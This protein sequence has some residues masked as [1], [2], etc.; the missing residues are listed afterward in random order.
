MI[1]QSLCLVLGAG[2]SQPYG[3]PTGNGLLRAATQ[4]PD[5]WWPLVGEVL[6]GATRASHEAFLKELAA[7]GAES[8]DEF[9]GKRTEYKDYAKAL[10]AYHI[11]QCERPDRVL[12]AER[13]HDW[14][15]FLIRRISDGAT[16]PNLAALDISVVTF[17]FDRS[18]EECLLARLS[19]TYKEPGESPASARTRVVGAIAN[20]KL[21]HVHGSL[22]PLPELAMSGPGRAYE[23]T[24]APQMLRQAMDGII[25]LNDAQSG[26]KEFTAA[27]ELIRSASRVFFLG[28]GFHRLNCA[29]VLPRKEDWPS[30]GAIACGTIQGLTKGRIQKVSSYFPPSINLRNDDSLALLQEYEAVFSD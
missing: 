26:S 14:L 30:P 1:T 7:S 9:V 11:G 23:S 13:E 20:W 4:M 28:F 18:Y 2:A 8:L 10:I 29:R 3:F 6:P 5:E 21:I 27:R 17:N 22:G 16:L 24:L 12:G 25:L 15:N 19:S